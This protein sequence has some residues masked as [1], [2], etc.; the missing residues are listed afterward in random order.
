MS[1][2]TTILAVILLLA[3]IPLTANATITRVM[4]MGGTGAAYIIKDAY[5]PNIWPQLIRN[6]ASIAGGEF[7]T[8][9]NGWDFQK[10][11]VNYD[12][13]EDKCAFQF[14]LD[15]IPGRTY[16]MAPADLDAV[17]GT[18]NRLSFIIGRPMGDLL[19]GLSFNYTGKSYKADSVSATV[20]AYDISYSTFG[21]RLGVSALEKKLD[22]AVGFDFASFSEKEGGK[23]VLDNDGSMSIGF[24]GR[25]WYTANER[26]ALIPNIKFS[27]VKD[28]GKADSDNSE[29]LTTT[30]FGVGI[31]N[32]WRPVDNLL[33]IFELGI[34]S[35]STKDELKVSG[36]SSST[37]DSDFDVYWRLG[38]E[39]KIFG[40]LDGRFGAERAWRSLSY[41]S[42]P[43]KPDVG[44][45]NTSTYLGATAHWN[46]FYLD[47]LVEP[48]FLK[49]GP[50][51]ISGQCT[52]LFS[53]VSLWYHFAE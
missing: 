52:D 7:Y 28:A 30:M 8:A 9:T 21:G 34:M 45:A 32:N 25:Y 31:G 35:S 18:Y 26:Y 42:M 23:T 40:W 13:G 12:F 27:Y 36:T 1:K 46:R 5:T 10:A 17:A 37:T 19:V 39:S 38:F 41:E 4:G 24:V 44:T 6:Y 15:K 53:R 3:L 49:N 16:T 33:S 14:S 20:P 22:V 47:L 43:G 50:Y 48:M 11:Y 51:F 29:A 2:K